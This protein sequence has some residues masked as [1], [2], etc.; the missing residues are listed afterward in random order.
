MKVVSILVEAYGETPDVV[1]GTQDQW[2]YLLYSFLN[3]EQITL[4]FRPGRFEDGRSVSGNIATL[5]P[6]R[7]YRDRSSDRE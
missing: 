5:K 3:V 2:M 1:N 7:G 6:S 4:G